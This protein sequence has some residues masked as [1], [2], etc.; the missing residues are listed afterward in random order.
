MPNIDGAGMANYDIENPNDLDDLIRS[1][2]IWKGGPKAQTAGINRLIETGERPTNLPAN[3][4]RVLPEVTPERAPIP[5]D[6]NGTPT[7]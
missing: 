4:A 7:P 3:I 1:G 6:D 5:Q 2:L